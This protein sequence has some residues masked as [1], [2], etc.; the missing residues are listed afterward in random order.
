VKPPHQFR[1]FDINWV[2]IFEDS[3]RT[4]ENEAEGM[5][6]FVKVGKFEFDLIAGV[7]V[8]QFEYLKI[9]N[10]NES[11]K[12]G[13]FDA[14]EIIQCLLFGF[15]QVTACAFLFDEK[16]SLP[17]Q[18]D[19][20]GRF[21]PCALDW[22]FEGGNLAALDAEYF[23]EFIVESLSLAL[24]VMGVF[25]FLCKLVSAVPNLVPGKAYVA[26]RAAEANAI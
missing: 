1:G 26:L 10:E 6:V 7:E 2:L 23:K 17:K 24:L 3:R 19:E 16:S 13:I 20:A 8:V 4:A 11:G 14:G 21:R 22:F 25:P 5:N 15:C 18:I 12:F 9:A